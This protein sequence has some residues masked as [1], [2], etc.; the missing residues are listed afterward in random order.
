MKIFARRRIGLIEEAEGTASSQRLRLGLTLNRDEV[1]MVEHTN[2]SFWRGK[3]LLAK[4]VP[5]SLEGTN[6][7]SKSTVGEY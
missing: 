7:T 5:K 1:G 2:R 3:T 4:D 6:R